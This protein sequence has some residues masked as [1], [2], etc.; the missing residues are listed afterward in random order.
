M[1]T[2]PWDAVITASGKVTD[3]VALCHSCH[4]NSGRRLSI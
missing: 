2:N 4:F 1:T 3:A